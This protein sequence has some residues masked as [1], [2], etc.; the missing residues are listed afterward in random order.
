MPESDRYEE[1]IR[2][3]LDSKRTLE[4]TRENLRSG[5]FQFKK[6]GI[7]IEAAQPSRRPIFPMLW[8]NIMVSG[9]FGLFIGII[10]ALFLEHLEDRKRIQKLKEVKLQEWV[11]TL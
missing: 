8:L 10:Y 11:K 6:A 9:M 5:S 2:H 3:Y 7:V 1:M 4:K